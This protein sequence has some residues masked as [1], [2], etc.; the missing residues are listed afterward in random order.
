MT[1]K[2]KKG[3]KEPKRI[4]LMHPIFLYLE[5]FIFEQQV[6]LAV[7][8]NRILLT[9]SWVKFRLLLSFKDE[10]LKSLLQT[11]FHHRVD[12]HSVCV[13]HFFRSRQRIFIGH[14][15]ALKVFVSGNVFPVSLL[16]GRS[17]VQKSSGDNCQK[18][19]TNWLY[20]PPVRHHEFF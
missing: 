7:F 13:F 9:L 16:Q 14:C 17:K 2:D 3:Q 4:Q 10:L 15:F 5:G 1:Q 6:K 8:K 19:L 18:I 11:S 12:K 20:T